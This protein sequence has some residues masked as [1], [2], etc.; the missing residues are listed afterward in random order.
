MVQKILNEKQ[1]NP[2]QDYIVRL[3]GLAFEFCKK[4]HKASQTIEDLNESITEICKRK[5]LEKLPGVGKSIS[6]VVKEF[7]INA[8]SERLEKEMNTW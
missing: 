2:P 8:R 5:A 6:K 4:Y 3:N 1:E 7:L